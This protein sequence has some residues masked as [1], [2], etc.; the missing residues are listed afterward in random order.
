MFTSSRGP[1]VS[2][3][4]EYFMLY[5]IGGEALEF[6]ADVLEG[7][8]ISDNGILTV[9]LSDNRMSVYKAWVGLD[10]KYSKPN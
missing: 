9:Y 7:H 2:T 1:K 10:Y 4:Y 3:K 6:D 5:Q 8:D